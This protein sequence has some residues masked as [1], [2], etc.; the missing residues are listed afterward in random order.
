MCYIIC[1]LFSFLNFCVIDDSSLR[2][3]FEWTSHYLPLLCEN[4]YTGV[5]KKNFFILYFTYFVCFSIL[6]NITFLNSISIHNSRLQFKKYE[7]RQV[8]LSHLPSR[9]QSLRSLCICVL[10]VPFQYKR[11]YRIKLK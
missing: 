3:N 9:Y 4:F 11:E 5:I 7:L 8:N 1:F 2:N 6:L 10:H